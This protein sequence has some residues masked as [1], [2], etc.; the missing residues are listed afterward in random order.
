[1]L[2]APGNDDPKLKVLKNTKRAFQISPN[3]SV[4]TPRRW[5]NGLVFAAPWFYHGKLIE[6]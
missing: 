5:S 4:C 3:E 1:V 6:V 2:E